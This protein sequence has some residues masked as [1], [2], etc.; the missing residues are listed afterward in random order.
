M[1]RLVQLRLVSSRYG[2]SRLGAPAFGCVLMRLPWAGEG[3][4]G[5]ITASDTAGDVVFHHH[6][7]HL[8]PDPGSFTIELLTITGTKNVT[9]S[10]KED[11][12]A[13]TRLSSARHVAMLTSRPAR[14]D[15]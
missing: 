3:T 1:Q 2:A 13:F 7:V 4:V 15:S 14:V 6:G 12:R 10:Q 5:P 8:A 9:A 11:S